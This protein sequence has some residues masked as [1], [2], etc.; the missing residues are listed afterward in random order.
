[1]AF[2]KFGSFNRFVI[3]WWNQKTHTGHLVFESI[4]R[5]DFPCPCRNIIDQIKLF[6]LADTDLSKEITK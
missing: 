5:D 6:V 4:A 1:L 3:W 2:E